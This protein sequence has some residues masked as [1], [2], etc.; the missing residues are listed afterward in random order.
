ARLRLGLARA[1]RH[2]TQAPPRR[3][4]AHRRRRERA[5]AAEPMAL[6]RAQRGGR[7]RGAVRPSASAGGQGRR[8]G[9]LQRH[10]RG[11]P[12]AVRRHDV[13]QN[14]AG[15][16]GNP[17][18]RATM[19][20]M[21]TNDRIDDPEH[22]LYDEAPPRS[23]FATM[24]FRAVLVLIV[25]AVV[26]AVAVPYILDATNP[27]TKPTLAPR[28]QPTPAPSPPAVTP[29]PP[30]AS[31]FSAQADKAPDKP[32]SPDRALADRPAPLAQ[33]DKSAATTALTPPE[34]SSENL[35]DKKDEKVVAA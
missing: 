35:S 33:A 15:T 27:P 23:I 2:T 5:H 31:P 28:P 26:V 3:Q 20:R 19:T 1:G 34:K 7:L 10:P 8:H 29:A 9:R 12:G 24:W 11:R 17:N 22:D 4:R 18:D 14:V 16:L 32:P 13:R 21:S 25:L 30:V 6:V